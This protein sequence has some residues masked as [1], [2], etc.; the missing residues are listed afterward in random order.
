VGFDG[1]AAALYGA[2]FA[3]ILNRPPDSAFIA[4]G[5]PVTVSTGRRIQPAR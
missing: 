2:N 1:D 3:A 5:S 4:E